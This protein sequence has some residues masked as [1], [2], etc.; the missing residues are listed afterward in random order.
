MDALIASISNSGGYGGTSGWAGDAA[1]EVHAPVRSRRLIAKPSFGST[2]AEAT[3][4]YVNLEEDPV[5]KSNR[6]LVQI[7]IVDPDANVPLKDCMIYKGDQFMTELEDNE[8]F[9]ELDIKTL[10][11]EHNKKRI[12]LVNKKIKDRVE[13]LEPARVKDL[14][15]SVVTVAAF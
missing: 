5:P 3:A 9:F 8:L 4:L 14:V 6:R 13:N 2:L 11:E 10:L 1:A 12:T 15:M 7:F